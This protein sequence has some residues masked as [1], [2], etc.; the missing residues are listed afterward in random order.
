ML[1]GEVGERGPVCA[2]AG[3]GSSGGDTGGD[4]SGDGSSDVGKV[5]VL[6]WYRIPVTVRHNQTI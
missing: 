1:L 3:G 4:G 6:G 2:R 5:V